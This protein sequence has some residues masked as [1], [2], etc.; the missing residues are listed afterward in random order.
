M[1]AIRKK[2]PARK[3]NK[4]LHGYINIKHHAREKSNSNSDPIYKH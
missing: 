3:K 1:S 4:N 2:Q